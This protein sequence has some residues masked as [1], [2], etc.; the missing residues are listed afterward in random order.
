M[1][2]GL[3]RRL[4]ASY[5]VSEIRG[6]FLLMVAICDPVDMCI[7]LKRISTESVAVC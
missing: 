1:L 4:D 3:L 2:S 7:T 6:F 5:L